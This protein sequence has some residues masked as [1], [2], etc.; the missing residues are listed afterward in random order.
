VEMSE[1]KDIIMDALI[2]TKAAVDEGVVIGG[3]YALLYAVKALDSLKEDNFDKSIGIEIV[4][5]V[6]LWEF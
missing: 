6:I 2:G 5:K 3:D 1:I 4:K